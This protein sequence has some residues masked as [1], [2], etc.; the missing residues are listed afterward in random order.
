MN[1]AGYN[2]APIELEEVPQ[3]NNWNLNI[4]EWYLFKRYPGIILE[5][6]QWEGERF[7]MPGARS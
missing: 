5:M 1:W 2:N 3:E 6:P 4:M 7:S